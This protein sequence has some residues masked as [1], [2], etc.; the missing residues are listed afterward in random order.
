MEAINILSLG[1][2]FKTTTA[3]NYILENESQY[4]IKAKTNTNN[5]IEV[6]GGFQKKTIYV[7]NNPVKKISDHISF[8]P[9]IIHTPEDAVLE[10]KINQNR[11]QAINKNICFYS[12]EYLQTLKKY[13][14]TLQQRNKALK[15]QQTTTP[16]DALLID[17]SEQ[18]WKEK[19]KYKK[20]L[21]TTLK[22]ENQTIKDLAEIQIEEIVL[23]KEKIEKNLIKTK[24]DDYKKG[25][26]TTGPHKDKV[27]Y[28]LNTKEIKTTASQGEKTLFFSKLKKAEAETIK[29]ASIKKTDPIILLDDILSKLDNSNIE[30][31]FKLF[32]L[33]Q[34]TIITHTNKTNT[35]NTHQIN[36]ND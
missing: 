29:E 11:N 22:N 6:R 24:D 15:Q 12:K 5:T 7:D 36:I 2:S 28:F 8:L 4:N 30:K 13:T 21:N 20:N 17:F 31:L 27:K 14:H 35:N 10:T 9:T 23:N 3:K 19:E 32:T 34:Q 26:T 16:W 33:N 25:Y 1:K 18:I